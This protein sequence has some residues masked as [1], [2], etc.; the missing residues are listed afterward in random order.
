MKKQDI[1][2]D[3]NEVK[4]LLDTIIELETRI[5]IISSQYAELK[6]KYE[7]LAFAYNQI[8]SKPEVEKQKTHKI[9]FRTEDKK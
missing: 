8:V 6:G 7:L 1:N 3:V 2:I 9:G 5:G 4:K